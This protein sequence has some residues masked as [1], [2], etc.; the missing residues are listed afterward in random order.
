MDMMT[1]TTMDAPALAHSARARA[2]FYAFL[3][4]H[5]TALPDEIFVEQ[6]RG[7][8]CATM[9]AELVTDKAIDD[10]VAAGAD[11]MA[12]YLRAT[13]GEPAASLSQMLGVERTRL[14]RGITP[15]YGPPPPYELVWSKTH[16]DVGLLQDLAGLYREAGLAPA[17][18]ATD[19]PDYIGVELDYLR[20]LVVRE[21]EGW[22]AGTSEGRAAAL[23]A[24]AAQRSFL[25]EHLAHWAPFY[26]DKAMAHAKTDFYQGHLMM[27][28]GFIAGEQQA[29]AQP[30][31]AF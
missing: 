15:S 26:V 12:A 9:L 16:R 10:N 20:A 22:A 4:V 23:A 6:M 8:V 7:P 18:E 24:R 13:S 14:Y 17:P 1:D 29:L 19:R 25:D 28:Q 5:F 21:A 3:N 11:L 31:A 27:L 2:A 30:V